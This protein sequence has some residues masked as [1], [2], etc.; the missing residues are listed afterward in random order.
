MTSIK[1]N[2]KP[3]LT[4]SEFG[5]KRWSLHKATVTKKSESLVVGRFVK[6]KT[7]RIRFKYRGCMRTGD[8]Y[9]LAYEIWD[10]Q[11]RTEF[12]FRGTG[13]LKSRKL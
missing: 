7:V 10:I 3:E 13:I 5:L 11:D 1:C 8:A 6:G 2:G 9:V 4:T 12:E